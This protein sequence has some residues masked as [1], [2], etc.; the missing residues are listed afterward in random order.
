MFNN[1]QRQGFEVCV[2]ISL[3][4]RCKKLPPQASRILH[5][6]LDHIGLLA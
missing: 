2:K 1:K 6:R 5:T 3:Q 4:P